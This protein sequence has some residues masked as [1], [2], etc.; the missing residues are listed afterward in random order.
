MRGFYFFKEPA[1]LAA[2]GLRFRSKILDSRYWMLEGIQIVVEEVFADA[3]GGFGFSGEARREIV[4]AP[5]VGSAGSALPAVADQAE[6]LMSH[7][8]ALGPETM[9]AK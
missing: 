4:N 8:L 3:E 2:L 9:P 5:E 1:C 6:G 7:P